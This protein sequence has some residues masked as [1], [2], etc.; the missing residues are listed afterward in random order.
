MVNS[1]ASSAIVDEPDPLASLNDFLPIPSILVRRETT[2]CVPLELF[3]PEGILAR[4]G[5]EAREVEVPF[6]DDV[7]GPTLLPI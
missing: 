5:L 6:G 4:T 7:D 1:L 3:L 2:G